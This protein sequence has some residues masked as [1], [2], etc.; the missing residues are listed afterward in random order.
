MEAQLPDEL[1]SR[2]MLNV[3]IDFVI[4]LVPLLGDMLDIM[5]K[6]N[7]KNA[8]LFEHYLYKRRDIYLR[9]NLESGSAPLLSE[10]KEPTNVPPAMKYNERY[11]PY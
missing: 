1:V 10:Y 9:E 5:F 7:S 6:C 8:L 4:G 11:P 3:A 2:M